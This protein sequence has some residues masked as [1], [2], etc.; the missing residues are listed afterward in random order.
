MAISLATTRRILTV[1]ALTFV[2]AFL[3]LGAVTITWTTV[4]VKIVYRDS[5][6]VRSPAYNVEVI[7]HGASF[8]IT[9]RQKRILDIVRG[10]TGPVLEGARF[11]TKLKPRR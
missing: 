3:A 10:N 8:F 6:S 9:P 11:W 4:P 1:S 5:S 2:F 7:E